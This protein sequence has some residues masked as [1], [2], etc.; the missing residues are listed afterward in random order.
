MEHSNQFFSSK[1]SK[2][3]GE[4]R[5]I[6]VVGCG[7]TGSNVLSQLAKINY[8][9]R[10]L[11]KTGL[12]VVAYDCDEVSPFNVGRQSFS[13]YDIGE[14]KAKTLIS[15]INKFYGTQWVS[16]DC[17]YE[18]L[19]VKSNILI[20]CVDSLSARKK[21]FNLNGIS[22]DRDRHQEE[23]HFVI[24]CGNEKNFGQV[25]LWDRTRAL[26]DFFEYYDI[27]EFE[28]ESDTPSCSMEEAISKQSM[29]INSV[30]A[31]MTGILVEELLE[32]EKIY[33]QGIAVNL[34]TI[35]MKKLPIQWTEYGKNTYLKK[36]KKSTSKKSNLLLSQR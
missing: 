36:E 26:K 17:R 15:R 8:T 18:E 24:D 7:G 35:T 28:E 22:S 12:S 30:I 29:F 31:N 5:S 19:P 14:N 23:Q 2:S 21:I 32:N 25:L 20:S 33:Y 4:T 9:R 27:K 11:G 16:I 3:Y 10:A 6:V 13:K 34:E 1:L